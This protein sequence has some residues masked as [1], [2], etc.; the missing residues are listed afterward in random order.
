MQIHGTCCSSRGQQKIQ[1]HHLRTPMLGLPCANV[2][3]VFR[4]TIID[5]SPITVTTRSLVHHWLHRQQV[6]VPRRDFHQPPLLKMQFLEFSGEDPI[7]QIDNCL[8]YFQSIKFLVTSGWSRL[9]C[10]CGRMQHAG[11][12]CTRFVTV[13]SPRRGLQKQCLPNLVFNHTLRLC[14]DC[15]ASDIRLHYKNTSKTLKNF[16]TW[17]LSITQRLMKHFLWNNTSKGLSLI[18]KV[19]SKQLYRHQSI[20]P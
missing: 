16:G 7:T 8:N 3:V 12:K 20:E 19:W 15:W 1:I 17:F 9:H 2:D 5:L 6:T 10:M 13:L 4:V 14:A 18:F 11:I